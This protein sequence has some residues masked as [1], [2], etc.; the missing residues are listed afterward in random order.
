[1]IWGIGDLSLNLRI[2]SGIHKKE[3]AW[4][5]R[6]QKLDHLM[7]GSFKNIIIWFSG[8]TAVAVVLIWLA[9]SLYASLRHD[10]SEQPWAFWDVFIM[11][12]NPSLR[13]SH[14]FWDGVLMVGANVVGIILVNGLLLT[15]LVNWVS[16]RR[17]RHTKGTARYDNIKDTDFAVIIGGHKMVAP[18]VGQL[19][20]EGRLAYVLIQTQRPPEQVRKE[21]HSEVKD[22]ARLR[23]VVIY[24]G[25]RTSWQE[26]K[27]LHIE[28]AREVFII[29][30]PERIDGSSHDA[31]NMQCRDIL[32]EHI[33]G[34]REEKIPCHIMF[35]YQSTFSIFQTTDIEPEPHPTLRFIPFSVYETW[36]QQ[37]FSGAGEGYYLPLD[38]K[39]G[40]QYDSRGRVHLIVGGM[41][42]CGI[43]MA[44]EAAH[45]AH[46]PNFNNAAAGR[47]RTLITFVDRNAKR[48]M[49]FF[50]GRYRE[51][52]QLAR[53][54]YV[55]APEG[56]IPA[57]DGTWK[58]YDDTRAINARDNKL[59]PWH[60]PLRDAEFRSPYFGGYLGEDFIDIDFEFIEGDIALPAVGRYLTDASADAESLTTVAV[61]YDDAAE[62]MS[63]ALYFPKGVYE[64]ALQILVRQPESG[65]LVDAVSHGLT[66]EDKRQYRKMRAFGMI[67]RCDYLS[68]KRSLIP[69]LIAY[70]YKAMDSGST[71]EDELSGAESTE[72]FLDK[73]NGYWEGL[74]REK[75]KS[76]LAR[77]WSNVYCAN[78]IPTKV[79]SVR[80]DFGSEENI[81]RLAFTEHN[82]W[83][84]EQLLLGFRPLDRTYAERIPIR[85]KER[86]SLK[87]LKIHP[88]LLSNERLGETSSFDEG[89]V[90]AIP[91]VLR[92]AGAGAEV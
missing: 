59:Y 64:E 30:E 79:R 76:A 19:L 75:G 37:V 36:A 58:I 24:S 11:L 51:L 85:G 1:M 91:A 22:K 48:E 41:T 82:R 71:L 45:L 88:D 15:V 32:E 66:G 33:R 86:D 9:A 17:E 81:Q 70:A 84:M 68:R 90:R 83:I 47:P 65:A 31:L 56:V 80:G 73:V 10:G 92:I 35:E 20:E 7:A 34:G 78:S 49:L 3:G 44:L 27:E 29:G 8:I 87:A 26:L 74:K 57:D 53:W 40:L 55:K 77:E 72:A 4:K 50:M 67:D 25:D 12:T 63:A 52:F 62:A 5:R 39:E 28:R 60:D 18:L 23:D 21:I 13:D 89:I 16:E 6:Y 54:R 38:G 61:C 43:A 2:M 42:K 69:R 14:T 46:Y